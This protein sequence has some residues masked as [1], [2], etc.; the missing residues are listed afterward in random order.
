MP[1]TPMKPL[2]SVLWRSL[3]QH[4]IV[5]KGAVSSGRRHRLPQVLERAVT[6]RSPIL[7]QQ[8]SAASGPCGWHARATLNPKTPGAKRRSMSRI[9]LAQALQGKLN[10]L[11]PDAYYWFKVNALTDFPL[12]CT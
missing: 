9:Y 5:D 3:C 6:R 11:R 10:I 7:A 12:I 2:H 1:L 4:L 8:T